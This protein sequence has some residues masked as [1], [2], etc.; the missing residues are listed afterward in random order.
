MYLNVFVGESDMKH[1]PL[2]P[3]LAAVALSVALSVPV[4]LSVPSDVLLVPNGILNGGSNN[5]LKYDLATGASLG[6]FASSGDDLGADNGKGVLNNPTDIT[7]G[8]DGKV[9]VTFAESWTNDGSSP[10]GGVARFHRDGTYEGLIVDFDISP[11][12]GTF[13]EPTGITFGSNGKMYIGHTDGVMRY[14]PDGTFE[15]NI[16]TGVPRDI[17]AHGDRIYFQGPTQSGD[18]G[19]ISYIDVNTG[20][21]TNTST[22]TSPDFLHGFA[23]DVDN[24]RLYMLAGTSDQKVALWQTPTTG[25]FDPTFVEFGRPA[26]S[27]WAFGFL[28]HNDKLYLNTGQNGDIEMYDATSGLSLGNL[29]EDDPN[30]N[31]RSWGMVVIPIPELSSLALLLLF[32]PAIFFT[33]KIR[34]KEKK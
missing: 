8:P 4:T 33:R 13:R 5:I 17:Q 12:T 1:N 34:I 27:V 19:Y 25:S 28:Y 32:I 3:I 21:V 11:P 26:T 31:R 22:S 14:A 2:K 6:V 10:K 15:N 16:D 20:F 18:F 9:Y 24:D 30:L 7:L 23:S 29:V